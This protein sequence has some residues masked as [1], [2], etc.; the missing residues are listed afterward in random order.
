[1]HGIITDP[2]TALRFM[3]AGKTIITFR[4]Q[5]SGNHYT[6]KIMPFPDNKD[7]QHPAYRVLLLTGPNNEN[8]YSWLGRIWDNHFFLT[9]KSREMGLSDNTPSILA[10]RWV[11]EHLAASKMPPMTEIFHEGRCGRC[12]RTLSTPE[13]VTIGLGPICA[14]KV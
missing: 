9:P 6:Y 13:S 5:K 14:S 11:L 2:K 7:P 4:S 1:M 12:G 10:I 8:D 3:F